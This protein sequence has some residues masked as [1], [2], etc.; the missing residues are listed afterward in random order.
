MSEKKLLITSALPYANGPL[1]FG[2]I[3]G[4]YLPA[5]IYTRHQKLKGMKC[6]HISGSDEHGVPISMNAK[7]AG[8]GYQE[9]VDGWHRK[10]KELFDSYNIKFDFFGQTSAD[11]H[12]EETLLWFEE[13]NKK[14]AIEKKEE[15]QL[16]CQDCHNFL[17][18]RF[19][20]GTCY[21][22]G[23]EHARGDECPNCGILIE[24][25]KL[26][27][28]TCKFCESKNIEAVDSFQ[29]YLMQSKF[30]KEYDAWLSTKG[31]WKKTVYPYLE[32]L[33][34]DGL[35]NRA[36]TRDLDWGI[37]VPLKEAQ[38][39]K[40]YVWFDA[41]IGYVSNT[42]KLLENTDEDYLKDWWL[43]KDTELINFIGKDNIIFHGVI[44]PVMSMVS[45]R[46]RPVTTLP[47][48][49]YVNLKGKQFSKS[50]GWYVDAEDA[51]SEFGEDALRFYLAGLIPETSDSSFT[52]EGFEAKINGELANNIGNFINRSLKF[53]E[54][55]FKDE[56]RLSSVEDFFESNFC[57]ELF[58]EARKF[59]S[60]LD[61]F[62]FKKAIESLMKMGFISNQFFSDREPWAKI[63]TDK[64]HAALTLYYSSVACV[65]LGVFFEPLLP[66]L[67]RNIL[68][69][70]DSSI[71]NDDIKKE[72]Y[73]FKIDSFKE[74]LENNFLNIVKKPEGLVP[75]IDKLKIKELNEI[76]ESK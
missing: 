37:D 48:N 38:G 51:I 62:Q 23:Y 52:W 69:H 17:P 10:H 71:V 31:D 34:K 50:Q 29:W 65:L 46:A 41:P 26:K 7:K 4:V 67:S 16:Q 47:A 75:K 55:N 11:Y 66:N 45:G 36:I 25:L 8:V 27:S 59:S 73:N 14:N 54:K 60:F 21:E 35:V 1:H 3:A 68:S 57:K 72:I 63:K 76:L 61:E 70:F 33:N 2:H 49:Q 24:P 6:L 22:C 53:Y 58:E 64:D 39:K 28:P 32:S 30:Q 56:L 18:D 9:Y 40:F 13:L 42:K 15:K 20:E 12:K 74:N 44:F 19:V 5:D 43:N